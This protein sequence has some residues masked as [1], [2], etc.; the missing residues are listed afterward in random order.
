MP[1]VLPLSWPE[2]G[3]FWKLHLI[4]PAFTGI[5]DQLLQRDAACLQMW[6]AV[7][8][9]DMKLVRDVS[10][11]IREYM[12]WPNDLFIPDDPC[13]I[14]FHDPTVDLRNVEAMGV[15]EDR[16]G[17]VVDWER[18]LPRRFGGLIEELGRARGR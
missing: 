9:I 17:V 4:S 6:E 15:I 10:G 18:L 3:P 13:E 12:F 14:L 5:R 7:P 1:T 8:R 16:A 11:I 2:P